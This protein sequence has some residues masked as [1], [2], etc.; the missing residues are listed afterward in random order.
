MTECLRYQYYHTLILKHLLKTLIFIMSIKHYIV[1][2]IT[3]TLLQ[4]QQIYTVCFRM[5]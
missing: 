1:T 5:L 4:Y 3:F 2:N